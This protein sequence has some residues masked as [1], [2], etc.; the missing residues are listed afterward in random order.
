MR[1]SSFLNQRELSLSLLVTKDIVRFGI[2][3]V[4]VVHETTFR[5]TCDKPRLAA[6]NMG[7]VTVR[8]HS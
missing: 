5:K 7:R 1:E 6:T 2:N 4:M 8:S 3:V